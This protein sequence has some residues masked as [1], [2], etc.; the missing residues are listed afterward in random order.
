MFERSTT[1]WL[2]LT[3]GLVGFALAIAGCSNNG[4]A[5]NP[6]PP[7]MAEALDLTAGPDLTLPD[8]DPTDHPE[9]PQVQN[10]GG[11]V[12]DAPEIWTVVW[13]GDEDL[14][15]RV[16]KFI[17]WMLASDYWTQSLGEYAVHAGVSKGVIVLPSAPPSTIDDSALKNIVKSVIAGLPEPT[18]PNSIIS[19]V[20]PVN[21][22]STMQGGQGCVDYGGYHSQT[23]T[24]AGGATSIP[25][26]VNLQCTEMGKT[27]WELLTEVIS[28]EAAE[29]STDP[30]PFSAPG[31]TN[32]TVAVGGEIGDLCVYLTTSFDAH[33]SDADAGVSDETYVVQKLYSQVR[34]ATGTSDPCVPSAGAFFGAALQ[35]ADVTVKIDTTTGMG[36]GEILVEPFAYGDVGDITWTLYGT[37]MVDGLTVAPKTGTAHAGQT[38]RVSIQATTKAKGQQLPLFLEA[39]LADGT[40]NEWFGSLVIR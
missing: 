39:K 16:S 19:F 11:P 3:L 22:M 38:I 35:P 31:W 9:L 23:R 25:Y 18:N 12:I 32:D 4:L 15:A 2:A 34:A 1:L 29:A 14:G 28:H 27:L 7:D 40:A 10:F 13:Q 20:I 36:E 5:P 6:A 17:G 33:F 8:R 24:V 37:G 30:Y 26:M 21:T